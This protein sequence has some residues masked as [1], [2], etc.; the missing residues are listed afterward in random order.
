V[1]YLRTADDRFQQLP[2]D[3]CRDGRSFWQKRFRLRIICESCE[4]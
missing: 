4:A 1:Q 2:G 3:D